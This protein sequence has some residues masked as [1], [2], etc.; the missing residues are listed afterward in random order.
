M[1]NWIE[2]VPLDEVHQSNTLRITI[3]RSLAYTGEYYGIVHNRIICI[4]IV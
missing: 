1:D 3:P 2:H 4:I